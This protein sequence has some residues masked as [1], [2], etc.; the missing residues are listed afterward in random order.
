MKWQQLAGPG[1]ALPFLGAKCAH[2]GDLSIWEI[3][4]SGHSTTHRMVYPPA[5]LG[6]PPHPEMPARPLE[7]YLE[8]QDV[9]ARSPRA[10]AALLR[11]AVDVLL[12]EVVEGAGRKSLNDVIGMAVA[13]GLTPAV[14]QALDVLRVIGNDA[15]HP[16]AIVLDEQDPDAK[17]A[18]L[19]K[20]MNVVVE[21][22]VASPRLAREM[23]DT[24]PSGAREGIARR[25]S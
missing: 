21:Q 3:S 1:G 9:A 10:A 5:R 20:L 11:V 8:A 6:V 16:E 13:A 12:R 24:L 14:Q 23:L 22:M 4:G 17:V 19:S 15:L 2:C 18:S 7:L 25:D